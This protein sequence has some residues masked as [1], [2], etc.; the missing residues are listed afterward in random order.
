[1]GWPVM[2]TGATTTGQSS[3]ASLLGDSISHASLAARAPATPTNSTTAITPG[4]PIQKDIRSPVPSS[5]A[6]EVN[7][8]APTAISAYARYRSG[9]RIRGGRDAQTSNAA[10]TPDGRASSASL[11]AAI[12]SNGTSMDPTRLGQMK[13][14]ALRA[15]RGHHSAPSMT[16]RPHAVATIAPFSSSGPGRAPD[17]TPG[18]PRSRA[19]R[20]PLGQLRALLGSRDRPSHRPHVPRQVS[21][22]RGAA[23]PACGAGETDEGTQATQAILWGRCTYRHPRATTSALASTFLNPEGQ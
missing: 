23:A 15:T 2:L 9:P 6:T 5:T 13:S 17:R 8:T 4:P 10:A 1:M 21:G 7:A 11:L 16:V 19:K 12:Q 22:R 20:Y 18:T 14:T 3:R